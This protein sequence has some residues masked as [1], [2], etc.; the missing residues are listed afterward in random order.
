MFEQDI[1][2]SILV[3]LQT[4][5]PTDY[6]DLSLKSRFGSLGIT[7]SFDLSAAETIESAGVKTRTR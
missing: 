2:P 3:Q 4:T 6:L 5:L 1:D 7:A